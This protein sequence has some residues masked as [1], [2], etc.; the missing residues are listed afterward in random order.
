VLRREELI[1][2]E[3]RRIV[4]LESHTEAQEPPPFEGAPAPRRDPGE[5]TDQAL[6]GVAG[7]GADWPPPPRETA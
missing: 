3:R 2:S 4:I 1:D 5:L 6:D 7:G